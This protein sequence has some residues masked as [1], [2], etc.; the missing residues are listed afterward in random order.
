[1]TYKNCKQFILIDFFTEQL[2]GEVKYYLYSVE[3]QKRGLPHL[4]ILLWF[5]KQIN[6]NDIDKIIFAEIPD[7]KC[8][9]VLYDLV[10]RHMIHGP[11][12]IHNGG[13]PCMKEGKCS[14]R[15]PKEFIANTQ[16]G[17]DGYPNYRRRNRNHGGNFGI[18][19]MKQNQE[20][21]PF[22]VDNR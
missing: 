4:H 10:V 7:I 12:G 22:E 13:C 1:M 9:H 15:F 6:P 8:D 5:S 21:L 20:Y 2:F 17:C 14:K 3:W 16:I 18:I 11:C 19:N